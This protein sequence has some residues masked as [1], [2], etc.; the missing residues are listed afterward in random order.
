MPL[1]PL[2]IEQVRAAQGAMDA[3][4]PVGE[5]G[6][7]GDIRTP[8]GVLAAGAIVRNG[9]ATVFTYLRPGSGE[10]LLLSLRRGVTFRLHPIGMYTLMPNLNE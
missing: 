6:L 4:N 1:S 10:N 7:I 2:T 9:E 5:I 8:V 3:A